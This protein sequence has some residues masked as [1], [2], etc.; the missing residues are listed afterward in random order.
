MKQEKE[1]IWE[2]A[3]MINALQGAWRVVA[4]DGCLIDIIGDVKHISGDS[5]YNEVKI[6]EWGYF[7]VE[8]AG[9]GRTLGLVLNYN[10]PRNS[11]TLRMVR[12]VLIQDTDSWIGTLLLHRKPKFTFRLARG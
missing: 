8:V 3:A 7:K 2:Y 12:D 5:G 11:P 6:G 4:S 1:T 9:E 10:D